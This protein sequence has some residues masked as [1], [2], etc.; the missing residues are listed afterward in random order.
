MTDQ[1]KIDD[2]DLGL[3]GG[4]FPHHDQLGVGGGKE[5]KRQVHNFVCVKV[6]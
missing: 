2:D 1:A 5:A 6:K 3:S 4:V